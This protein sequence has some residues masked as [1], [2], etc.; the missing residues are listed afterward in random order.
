MAGVLIPDPFGG[1]EPL[2]LSEVVEIRPEPE[3]ALQTWQKVWREGIAPS[4]STAALVAL[5]RALVRD[6][7]RLIQGETCTPP[8]VQA[9]RDWP[10]EGACLVGYCGWQGDGLSTAAEVEEYF[11]RVA[12]GVE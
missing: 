1:A 9:V 4:L 10:V 8:P 3:P 5:E 2:D 12:H 6:D 7:P 11:A